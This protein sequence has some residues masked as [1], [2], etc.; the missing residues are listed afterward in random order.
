[1]FKRFLSL[2]LPAVAAFLLTSCSENTFVDPYLPPPETYVSHQYKDKL[3]TTQIIAR[4]SRYIPTAG[5][6]FQPK[7]DVSVYRVFY[8]THDYENKEIIASGLI[9]I[10]ELNYYFL[11][12]ISYQHGTAVRKSEVASMT[13]DLDYYVPFL[14]ASETGAIVCETD[15]I[16]LGFSEGVQHYFEP[17]EEANAV[18]DL[19]RSAGRLLQKTFRQLNL[20]NELFLMGYSQGGHATL[21]AQRLFETKYPYE[22]I[23]KA[24]APMAGFFSF[25]KSSQFNLLKSPASYPITSIYPFLIHSINSTQK[26][27]ASFDSIFIHPYDSL[28]NVVFDGEHDASFIN[29]QF[30]DT[31]YNTLQASFRNQLKDNPNTPFLLAAKKYDLINDWI[32]KTPTRF[33]HSE[34]D[35]VAF[36]DNSEIAFQTFKTKGGN[37]QL[38]SLGNLNHLDANSAAI[39]Q[40]RNWFYPLIKI[41]AY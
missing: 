4:I 11:P 29:A 35:E 34:A 20:S 17:T 9:Y 41:T 16:G 27:Y 13:G 40:V 8:K 38:I 3:T 36:Y 2:S 39:Q 37:V 32:P 22:F 30:P 33:F 21:A 23:L 26:V 28:V 15:G 1:M 10:P 14:F 19:L 6:L 31:I 25:E 5:S 24:S 7:Y 12:L 18:V